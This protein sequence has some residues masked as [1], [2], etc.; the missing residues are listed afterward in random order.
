MEAAEAAAVELLLVVYGGRALPHHCASVVSPQNVNK[1]TDHLLVL[2]ETRTLQQVH[3]CIQHQ[4]A[5][6]VHIHAGHDRVQLAQNPGNVEA[7]AAVCEVHLV[8]R[9]PH[10]IGRQGYWTYIYN[11]YT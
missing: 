2:I 8:L 1:A 10:I 7:F 11:T 9:V 6:F 3:P 4:D 5:L